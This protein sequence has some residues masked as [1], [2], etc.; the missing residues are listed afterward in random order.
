LEYRVLDIYSRREKMASCNCTGKKKSCKCDGRC[1]CECTCRPEV[2][3]DTDEKWCAC[4]EKKDNV[5]KG[6]D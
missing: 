5:E 1:N 4:K 2:F 6:S 3:E